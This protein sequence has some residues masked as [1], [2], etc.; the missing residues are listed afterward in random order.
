MK[1]DDIIEQL[2]MVTSL[3]KSPDDNAWLTMMIVKEV[4]TVVGED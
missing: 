4:P 2:D 1:I 3:C